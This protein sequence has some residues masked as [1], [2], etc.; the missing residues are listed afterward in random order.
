[1]RF[2][3]DRMKLLDH[4]IS[5]LIVDHHVPGPGTLAKRFGGQPSA[6]KAALDCLVKSGHL[7]QPEAGKYSVV[8][9]S[10]GRKFKIVRR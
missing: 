4:M 10:E 7:R 5:T 9:D 3:A 2:K 1:M 6:Y 8:M